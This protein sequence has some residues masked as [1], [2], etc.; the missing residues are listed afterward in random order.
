VV[1]VGPSENA[2]TRKCARGYIACADQYLDHVLSSSKETTH[3][4]EKVV[5]ILLRRYLENTD[6]DIR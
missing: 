4:C 1:E 3:E 6:N 2:G 5:E